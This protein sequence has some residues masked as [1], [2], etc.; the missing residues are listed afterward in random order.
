MKNKTKNTLKGLVLA[1]ALV[2]GNLVDRAEA[3][4]VPEQ[5][6]AYS[7]DFIRNPSDTNILEEKPVK[8]RKWPAYAIGAIAFLGLEAYK[9]RIRANHEKTLEK[10][11]SD[12]Q[13][14]C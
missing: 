9:T 4:E 13:I 2:A 7:Y 10:R 11:A 12:Y 6:N 14:Y 1:G 8:Q 5:S 3:Q